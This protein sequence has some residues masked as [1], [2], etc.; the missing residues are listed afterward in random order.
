MKIDE[1]SPDEANDLLAQNDDVV[2]LDVRTE[3]EF[4][5]GHPT[6]AYN[7]P[8]VFMEPG[9]PAQPNAAFTE[10]VA[11]HFTTERRLVVGCQSGMRSMK[12][13]EILM[14]NGYTGVVNVRGGFGGTRDRSG[15]VL[16]AG[17][18]DSG[19]PVST[20]PEVGRSHDELKG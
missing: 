20:T 10:T 3:R 18:R 5:Q 15:N 7:V 11:R 12:A 17:W 19:L 9:A 16:V 13:C 2:Y 6:G 4:A 14:A 8:V 1:L